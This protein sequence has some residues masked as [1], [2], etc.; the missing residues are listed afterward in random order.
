MQAYIYTYSRG[1]S[2]TTTT[3]TPTTTTTTTKIA[4]STCWRAMVGDYITIPK[5][6]IKARDV[7][8]YVLAR[9]M[10]FE[11]FYVRARNG[12]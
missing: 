6:N 4:I 5:D 9:T 2:T 8:L 10:L 12:G 7:K 3:T 11:N 1:G